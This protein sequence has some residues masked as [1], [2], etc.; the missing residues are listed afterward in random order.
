MPFWICFCETFIY[1]TPADVDGNSTYGGTGESNP[2]LFTWFSLSFKYAGMQSLYWCF[3][4]FI[5]ISRASSRLSAE[6][7]KPYLP[8]PPSLRVKGRMT[9]FS[10]LG[11][12][13]LTVSWE[14]ISW[15]VSGRGKGRQRTRLGHLGGRGQRKVSGSVPYCLPVFFSSSHSPSAATLLPSQTP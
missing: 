4:N 1:W 6:N 8:I 14:M 15:V 10:V 13:N 9:F 7:A 12:K 3:I 5:T 11:Q 2:L